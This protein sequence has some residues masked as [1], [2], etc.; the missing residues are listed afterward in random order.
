MNHWIDIKRHDTGEIK[1]SGYGSD[2]EMISPD[3]KE[4]TRMFQKVGTALKMN[5]KLK[6]EVSRHSDRCNK[7]IDSKERYL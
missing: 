3:K 4:T 2:D 1:T 6:E 7:V 5:F